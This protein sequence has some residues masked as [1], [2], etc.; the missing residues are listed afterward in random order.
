MKADVFISKKKNIP[1]AFEKSFPDY[2]CFDLIL[3][4]ISDEWK[5]RKLFFGDYELIYRR[6]RFIL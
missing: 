2:E 4:F 6:G 1:I 3:K 5:K